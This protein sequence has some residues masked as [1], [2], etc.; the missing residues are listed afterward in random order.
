MTPRF[1]YCMD[2]V[3]RW[4]GGMVDDPSDR[5]GRTAYGVT[6]NT[7]DEYCRRNNKV[8][9]DVWTITKEDRDSVYWGLFWLPAKCQMFPEPLDLVVFD[10]AVQH[11][12]Q[13]AVKWLQQALG[14]TADGDFGPKSF[15]ALKEEITASRIEDLCDEYLAIRAGFYKGIVERDMSQK[16]FEKG[17]GNRMASL[18]LDVQKAFV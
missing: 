4:E 10:S 6:Q 14:V 2:F 9:R 7:W 13:R 8:S 15:E 5:G 11:G 12:P 18:N 3:A 17:W 16:R 1:K